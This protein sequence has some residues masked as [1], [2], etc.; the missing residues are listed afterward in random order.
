MRSDALPALGTFGTKLE[1]HDVLQHTWLVCGAH[2]RACALSMAL[3]PWSWFMEF[4]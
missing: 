4:L 1:L 2:R 3:E